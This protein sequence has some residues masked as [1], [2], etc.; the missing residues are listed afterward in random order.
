MKIFEV[1]F[2]FLVYL[3]RLIFYNQNKL[4]ETF[5]KTFTLIYKKG[6]YILDPTKKPYHKKVWE[7]NGYIFSLECEWIPKTKLTDTII[8]TKGNITYFH[9]TKILI[10]KDN[11]NFTFHTYKKGDWENVS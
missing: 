8:V 5:N 2:E 4:K 11:T 3:V 10:P 7:H 9:A 1:I 6:R